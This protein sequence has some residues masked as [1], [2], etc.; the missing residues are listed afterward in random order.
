MKSFL[1]LLLVSVILLGLSSPYLLRKDDAL[2]LF[3]EPEV[4]FN[5]YWKRQIV[6]LLDE[7]LDGQN[8]HLLMTT[9]SS[10]TLTDVPREDIIILD[11][12]GAFTR[13][14]RYPH[15]PTL[16][17]DPSDIMVHVFQAPFA[18]GQ[19]AVSRIQKSLGAVTDRDKQK[20]ELKLLK[21]QV[22]PGYWSYR[23]RKALK[24]ME[25]A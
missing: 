3:D 4:H 10:I 20:A 6:D 19:R 9:H 13:D 12:H 25:K 1:K 14:A 18:S 8:V 2:I 16:A 11:R 23:I 24:G 17:A 15:V 21:E 5:D 22:S 7:T